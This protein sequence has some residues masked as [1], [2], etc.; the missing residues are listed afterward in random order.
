LSDLQEQLQAALPSRYTIERELGRGGMGTVFLA[1]ESHPKRQVAIKVLNPMLAARLGRERFLREVDFASQL[2]H[3]LIVP[4]FSAGEAGDLLYY[5]M[6]YVTGETLRERLSREFRLPMGA[7]LG[8]AAELADALAHAHRHNIVHRDIKPENILLHDDHALIT[9]FGIS[10]AVSAAETDSLTDTGMTLGTPAYMSP[11]QA[12]GDEAV[13]G[14]ADIY[15]VACVLYEML[16]G[17]PPYGGSPARAVL[18]RQVVDPVP[19]LREAQPNIPLTVD[20]AVTKALAKEPNHRHKDADSFARV[21]SSLRVQVESG[22]TPIT[23][24]IHAVTVH[25]AKASR[26]PFVMT[27]GAFVLLLLLWRFLPGE[28][29]IQIVAPNGFLDSVAILPVDNFTG[30]SSMDLVADAV[31]YDVIHELSRI[32]QLKVT[33]LQSVRA[34]T[35]DSLRPPQLGDSLGVRLILTSSFRRAGNR[36]RI[37]AE[38]IDAVSDNSVWT[39]R[40]DLDASDRRGFE[41]AVVSRLVEGIVATADGLSS[42]AGEP[43]MQ[44]GPGYE[45]YLLG[46]ESLGQR[47]PAGVSQAIAR[48][49]EAIALDP[50][51][52]PAFASLSTAYA[53]TLVYRYNI[54]VGGYETAGL[55]LAAANRAIELDPELAAGY[56]ARGFLASRALGPTDAAAADFTRA[57]ELQP[58]APEQ[59]S[60][61]AAILVQEGRTVEAMASAERG[62]S[63]AP[64]SPA[65]H[66]ALATVALEL[67][68]YGIAVR[69][70]HRVTELEPQITVSRALEGHALL[71][72]GRLEQCLSVDFGPHDVVRA[73]CLHELG[74]ESEATTIVDSVIGEL[75]GS[76]A[77]DARYT[78]VTRLADLAAYYA[79]IGDSEN[80]LLWLDRAF[81]VSPM[82][83]WARILHTSLFSRMRNIPTTARDLSVIEANVWPR[84]VAASRRARLP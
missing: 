59:P 57:L 42:S 47:T 56:A 10:R 2:T 7:A 70:A 13:D 72:A 75:G 11:E 41:Q 28:N 79:W 53:L 19:S 58:N 60:W 17:A 34:L 15:A 66:L 46:S 49:R 8:I 81:D 43:E 65:R 22:S 37:G 16:D 69:E 76:T 55:A 52:A 73:T 80:M 54:G 3:P 74:R 5:V 38:L 62:V 31:T 33:S 24:A 64:Y 18:R 29:A 82:G 48:F 12:G 71:L 50:Q 27:V 45:A 14:R 9:D 83:V 26:V 30:D 1:Q 44:H 25:W 21:L 40:W 51:F 23:T 4:I 61:Y 39:E 63:L 20:Q 68:A 36:V 67:N 77:A 84:V 35:N 32:K 78:D 6:P